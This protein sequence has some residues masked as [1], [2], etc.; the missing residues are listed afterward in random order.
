MQSEKSSVKASWLMT[1]EEL[2]EVVERIRENNAVNVLRD[3][4]ADVPH[5]RPK[6]NLALLTHYRE[7][8]F[9]L[10][11]LVIGWIPTME[12]F[13][14]KMDLARQGY[15][16]TQLIDLFDDRLK[17]LPGYSPNFGSSAPVRE[18]RIRI[19]KASTPE[20]FLAG[21]FLVVKAQM[22][23]GLAEHMSAC[24]PIADWPTIDRL[25]SATRI[26]QQQIQWAD[27]W[28]APARQDPAK[29]EAVATWCDYVDQVFQAVGGTRGRETKNFPEPPTTAGASLDAC[30]EPAR[31]EEGFEVT[32]AFMFLSERITEGSLS[33]ILYHN[34]TELFVCDGLAYMIYDIEG[35]PYGFYRDFVRQIWDESRHTQ[36]GMRELKRL[37]VDISKLPLNTVRR[38]GS[39]T[40]TLATIGYTGEGCSFPRKYES[41]EGFY[42]QGHPYPALITEYDIADEQQHVRQI[43]RWLPKLHE[44]EKLEQSLEDVIKQAQLDAVDRWSSKERGENPSMQRARQMVNNFGAFCREVDFEI[45][46]NKVL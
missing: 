37:Q 32:D 40:H 30:A 12:K 1:I 25:E 43:H 42:K 45:N 15:I 38:P 34:L 29:A 14:V 46:F 36:M 39:Y 44:N 23:Q 9:Q 35:M 27:R 5:L 3:F 10:M 11:R 26:I 19:A 16:C 21:V 24:D 22:L 41:V 8:E 20:A 4:K 18:M 33:D 13:E 28:V 31:I 6:E 7:V 2:G 17:E